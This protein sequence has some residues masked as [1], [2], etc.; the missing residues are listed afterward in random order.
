MAGPPRGAGSPERWPHA[1]AT[2]T[3]A[4]MEILLIIRFCCSCTY[5]NP[6]PRGVAVSPPPRGRLEGVESWPPGLEQGQGQGGDGEQVAGP[7]LTP[8]RPASSL[9]LNSGGHSR[10]E[11]LEMGGPGSEGPGSSADLRGNSW[12]SSRGWEQL[13]GEAVKEKK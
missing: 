2:G 1:P 8:G 6:A 4:A 5:G 10:P 9:E 7:V 11:G 13:P 3:P 12:L